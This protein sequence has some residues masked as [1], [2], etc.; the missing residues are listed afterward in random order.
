MHGL[1]TASF[2]YLDATAIGR[3]KTAGALAGGTRCKSNTRNRVTEIVVEDGDG[4]SLV[5]WKG[6][7]S[8][9]TWLNANFEPAWD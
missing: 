8:T 5:K 9:Q 3:S 6:F 1:L 2:T 7:V 4:M